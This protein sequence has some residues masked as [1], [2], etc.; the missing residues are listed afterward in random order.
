VVF[1]EP[2]V[3]GKPAY[4]AGALC[5]AF[6]ALFDEAHARPSAEKALELALRRAGA[7]GT[8]LVT[9]SAYLVGA[10]RGRWYSDR[11]VLVDRTPWPREV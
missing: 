9:G 8:V 10:L 7:R 4:P 1:T 2:T 5:A 11:R 6:G 3:R